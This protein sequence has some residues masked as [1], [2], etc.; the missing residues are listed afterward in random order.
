MSKLSVLLLLGLS[1]AIVGCSK[2]EPVTKEA[3][4]SPG[5]STGPAAS[6]GSLKIVFI[7]KNTGNPYF[8]PV[9]QGFEDASKEIK[10]DFTTTAPATGDA[11]SQIAII[12]DQIQRGV[13]VIAIAPNSPDALNNVLDEAKKKGITILTVDADLDKNESHRDAAVLSTD[14]SKIGESQVELL[15]SLIG[16]E[17]P[18]AILSATTDAPNQN[19]WIAKMKETLK[20]P[21][22]AKMKLV[23]T[24]YGDDQPEKSTTVCEGLLSTHPDLRGI[25]SPTS[26]GLAAAAQT[27]KLAGVYPGGPHATGKG[28]QLTGL[29]TPNQLKAFVNS[30][31][32]TSFQLWSPHDMGY[33]ATY[34]G[35]AIHTGKLKAA[36]GVEID[37]PNL[38]KR[39][40]EKNNVISAGPLVTFDKS[41]IG[42][43]D[44]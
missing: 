7:P 30:G 5:A 27:I 11:T 8:K 36:K 38:G 10:A 16:Y 2:E 13:D 32:V 41:N 39:K 19:V 28:L 26:V 35:Q 34:L 37:V 6:G 31:V 22:Y 9:I 33:I 12:K 20:L 25:I 3:S 21:K 44:F 18:F 43:Y 15:G 24:V 42:K 4:N 14:F 23:D 40:L 17:G 29:S 1:V